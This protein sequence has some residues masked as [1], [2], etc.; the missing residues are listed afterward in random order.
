M[1]VGVPFVGV[2]AGEEQLGFD[3]AAIKV[4]AGTEVT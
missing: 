2:G 1:V 3:P 4:S